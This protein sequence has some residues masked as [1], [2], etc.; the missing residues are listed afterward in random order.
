VRL[1]SETNIR[2]GPLLRSAA[3]V[4]GVAIKQENARLRVITDEL[5]HRIK[6]VV[7]IIQSIARQTMRQT[8]TKNDFDARLSGRREAFGRS[9]D[10]LVANDW[11]GAHIDELVRSELTVFGVLDGAQIAVEGSRLALNPNAARNIGLALHEL[12]TNA[13]KY[14][15]SLSQRARLPCIGSS[16]EAVDSDASS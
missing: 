2:T 16:R 8:T 5:S 3:D 12:A 11:H 4:G 14:G 10:L 7:G 6:N 13:Y 15:L 1:A 9:L